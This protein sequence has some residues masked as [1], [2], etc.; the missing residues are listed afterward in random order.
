MLRQRNLGLAGW[1]I[2]TALPILFIAKLYGWLLP[3][4]RY[5]IASEIACL[6][7]APALAGLI[8]WRRHYGGLAFALMAGGFY[9]LMSFSW[10]GWS[11]VTGLGLGANKHFVFS[12]PECE[13]A[14]DFERPPEL[15]RLR[16]ADGSGLPDSH[17]AAFADIAAVTAFRADC[18]A[19]DAQALARGSAGVEMLARA[20]TRVWADATRMQIVHEDFSRD[21][22]HALYRLD[23]MVGG[24][25]LPDADDGKPR[26]TVAAIWTYIGHSSVMT[27]YVL[28]SL[29]EE[30]NAQS[31][32]FLR[33]VYRR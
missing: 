14:I 33:G 22:D 29:G 2:L 20:A 19:L 21:A 30:L 7:A 28:Q 9:A 32:A 26:R 10:L 24:S 12:A 17:T 3:F 18:T 5:G 15:S 1:L 23:G 27:V 31:L 25:V 11:P 16:R 8:T 4:N 13:F 6:L